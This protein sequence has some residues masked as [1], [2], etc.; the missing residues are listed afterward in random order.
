MSRS[1]QCERRGKRKERQKSEFPRKSTTGFR[2]T[3]VLLCLLASFELLSSFEVPEHDRYLCPCL[4]KLGFHT[5]VNV[6]SSF[7]FLPLQITLNKVGREGEREGE[8]A[9]ETERVSKRARWGEKTRKRASERVRENRIITQLLIIM[10]ATVWTG[11]ISSL[12]EHSRE[13]P[14]AHLGHVTTV[15]TWHIRTLYLINMPALVS[16]PLGHCL[17]LY[18]YTGCSLCCQ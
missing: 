2:K 15:T 13:P 4:G 8:M 6:I 12:A 18:T 11:Q 17:T 10:P 3:N 7:L 14:L 5:S 9:A 16:P 1:A